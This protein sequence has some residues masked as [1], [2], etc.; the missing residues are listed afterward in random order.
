MQNAS[1][2]TFSWKFGAA[3]GV[4]NSWTK[5][6]GDKPIFFCRKGGQ[7]DKIIIIFDNANGLT[8]PHVD[9]T[10]NIHVTC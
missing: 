4:I 1:K 5:H 6:D 8:P 7:W 9:V 2:L 10:R 3:L